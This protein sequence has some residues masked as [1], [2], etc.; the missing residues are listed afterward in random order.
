MSADAITRYF[1]QHVLWDVPPERYQI[2]VASDLRELIP[3]SVRSI[4]DVGC[5]NGHITHALAD[6]FD[7]VG[8]DPSHTALARLNV[9]ATAGSIEALPFAD[10]AFDLVMC[11]DVLEHLPDAVRARGLVELA[12]V[13]R[14]FVIVTVPHAEDLLANSAQCAKCGERYHLNGHLR[15][16]R[17]S[18]AWKL[19]LPGFAPQQLR[20]SGDITVPPTDPTAPLLH[21]IG[22]AKTWASVCPACGSGRQRH[23]PDSDLAC[24]LLGG[25][26]ADAWG[27]SLIAGQRF[28]P[29]SEVMVLFA[30]EG[31]T[32]EE[33]ARTELL[34][35]EPLGAV[36]FRNP[37]QAIDRE[38]SLGGGWARYQLHEGAWRDEHGVFRAPDLHADA[39]V[40]ITVRFP[41]VLDAGDHILLHIEG[42]SAG[43]VRVFTLE[44]PFATEHEVAL[45]PRAS[46]EPG[47]G[48]TLVGTIKSP[49]H[50]DRFG[51]ALDLY[52]IGPVCLRNIEPF[53]PG[54]TLPS[55]PF[56][57]VQPG[58]N[59]VTPPHFPARWQFGLLS[60]SAGRVPVWEAEAPAPAASVPWHRVFERSVSLLE[61]AHT[62]LTDERRLGA[63]REAA[64][65]LAAQRHEV[66]RTALRLAAQRHEVERTALT[67]TI[68]VLESR[69]DD[70]NSRLQATLEAEADLTTRL[71]AAEGRLARLVRDLRRGGLPIVWRR[72][73]RRAT[74]LRSLFSAL[75]I[76]KPHF[77]APW[78]AIDVPEPI[79]HD[80]PRVLIVSHMYP[81]PDQPGSGV[82]VHE[83]VRAL[84]ALG[85]DARVVCGYPFWMHAGPGPGRWLSQRHFSS[86]LRHMASQWWDL[87]GVPVI[88]VP[89]RITGGFENHAAEY[90]SAVLRAVR[91]SPSLQAPL[92]HA[93]TAYLDGSAAVAIE[94]MTGAPFV[95]TEHTGPF[96]MLL[97][98]PLVRARTERALAASRAVIAVSTA[99]AAHIKPSIAQDQHD[100]LAVVP[101]GVDQSLFFPPAVWQPD[102]H[103]PRLLFVGYLVAVKNAAVLLRALKT[104]LQ[105][106]PGAS[107]TLIGDGDER[108]ALTDLAISLGIADS[109]RFDGFQPR[110]AVATAMREQCDLLILPSRSET[111]GCVLAEALSCGKPVVAT[112]C[113]GPEDIVVPPEDGALC[114]VDDIAALADAILAEIEALPHRMPSDIAAR[115]R[116]R[117]GYDAVAAT[118]ARLHQEVLARAARH[119]AS[120]QLPPTP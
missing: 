18:D 79:G 25:T 45:K 114:E 49:L 55:A 1:S 28:N 77:T 100:K 5:G 31:I 78:R 21:D 35:P 56:A 115:A 61:N 14:Q 74:A 63:E 85:I 33:P 2:Q 110:A 41:F 12:R 47:G 19:G 116:A 90:E 102:V 87:D 118:I 30:R 113:G 37:S 75:R 24:A 70:T 66:E 119:P 44:G 106:V 15:T 89:Y 82:F 43:T 22:A 53:R 34:P 51:A 69:L 93:H 40:R 84:R 4:L 68:A 117:F 62:Q 108:A 7:V 54:A 83:Q 120:R 91:E 13:A 71:A 36:D 92:V 99:Q 32:L 58:L 96:S 48:A 98:H 20:F 39:P 97:A 50:C 105:R 23:R 29:H 26:R 11:N 86:L 42:E 6:R 107:L 57:A 76:P 109:V 10:G 65:R 27:D 16:S 94:R 67:S 112:R 60:R 52:L 9:P 111:F 72:V 38:W 95:I 64:L 17:G 103:R 73:H 3:D 59:V 80:A 81:H 8:I 46:N 101:N 104:I 88:Y